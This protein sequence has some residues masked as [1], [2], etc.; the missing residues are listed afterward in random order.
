M[1]TSDLASFAARFN[2][3]PAEAYVLPALF[4]SAAAKVGLPVRALVAQ[5][6]FTNQALG[7]YLAK[8]ARKVAAEDRP[9]VEAGL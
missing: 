1:L 4:E 2:I 9:N 3:A 7:E 5:A 8:A 6:T